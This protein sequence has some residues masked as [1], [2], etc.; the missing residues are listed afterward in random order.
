MSKITQSLEHL[1]DVTRSMKDEF[2][3]LSDATKDLED[4]VRDLK[5]EV[6][7]RL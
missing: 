1:V 5:H 4:E 6:R 7:E 3:R 2:F